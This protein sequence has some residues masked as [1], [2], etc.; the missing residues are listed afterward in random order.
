M[1]P[2]PSTMALVTDKTV[3]VLREGMPDLVGWENGGEE[4]IALKPH[5]YNQNK[6]GAWRYDGDVQCVKVVEEPSEGGVEASKKLDTV[7]SEEESESDGTNTGGA[8]NE[9]DAVQAGSD[10]DSDA[11]SDSEWA[12]QMM[13]TTK[14]LTKT[15]KIEFDRDHFGHIL[16]FLDR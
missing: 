10:T 9:G 1:Q 4:E 6:M 2:A 15:R 16:M 8:E 3:N 12:I 11:W 7:E 14:I 13:M 5:L